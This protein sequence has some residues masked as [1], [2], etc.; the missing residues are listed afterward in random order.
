VTGPTVTITDT[1]YGPLLVNVSR[2]TLVAGPLSAGDGVAVVRVPALPLVAT[3]D[4]LHLQVCAVDP[5]AV[6][7]CSKL[8][9]GMDDT[10]PTPSWVNDTLFNMDAVCGELGGPH[11][12]CAGHTQDVE[13]QVDGSGLTCRFGA[14]SEPESGPVVY[15]VCWTTTMG[16]ECSL[17]NWT[18]VDL[19]GNG[20]D[21][22]ASVTGLRMPGGTTAYCLVRACNQA[23]LCAN[24]TR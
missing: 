24:K 12:I 16:G 3:G 1:V 23:G 19:A 20:S 21:Y 6:P 4:V 5:N 9:V 18:T 17:S 8:Y 2:T 11:P 13:Y 14:A 15:S 22:N 7:V 10:P